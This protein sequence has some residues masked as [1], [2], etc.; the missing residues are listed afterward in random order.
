ML[1][2]GIDDKVQQWRIIRSAE[3]PQNNDITQNFCSFIFA[4]NLGQYLLNS[5]TVGNDWTI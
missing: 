2:S 5:Q 1:I 4:Q 3:D